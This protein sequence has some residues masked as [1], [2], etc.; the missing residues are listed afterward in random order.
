RPGLTA[1]KFVPEP[2]AGAGARMYRTGDRARWQADGNLLVLGR[3]DNQVKVRG[4][5]VELGEIEAVLRR[6]AS[7]TECVVIVREDRPG[8]RR[9]VAYVMGDADA[10]ALR[11]HLRGTLPEYMVP[12]AFVVLDAFPHTPTGKLDRKTLP[13]PEYA[14]AGAEA[15]PPRNAVEVQLIGLWEGLLGIEGVGPAQSFFDLGGNSLLALQ[16]FAKIHRVLGCDLPVAALYEGPTVRQMADAILERRASSA[17]PEA[18]SA[19]VALRVEGSL[20]PLFC[21]HPADRRV[22]VYAPLARHLGADQPVFGLQDLGA[23]LSRPI[24][25]IAAEYVTAL[26][27]VQPQGPYYLA[28]WSFGGFVAYEMASKLEREGERVAFVGM[29]DTFE[30]ALAQGRLEG[31]TGLNVEL[32][33]GIASDVAAQ[34]GRPFTIAREEMEGLDEDGRLRRAVEILHAHAAAPRG[35]D[36]AMLREHCT[37]IQAREASLAAYVPGPF[38]GPLTLFRAGTLDEEDEAYL[39]VLSAEERRTLGWCRRSPHPVEVR[40]APGEHVTMGIEPNVRA[41]AELVRESLASARARA[42]SRADSSG[43]SGSADL[44][45]SAGSADPADPALDLAR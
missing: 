23:D 43:S 27:T 10:A 41:L 11:G 2:F 14:H 8:D 4:F 21:V 29:L 26:R 33:L 20:P 38:S 42:A 24:P 32:V 36:A 35:F 34:M 9:L 31:D 44:P 18:A 16:L 28:G 3:T 6:H 15:G 7:V 39:A 19:V 25:A 45:D 5:R 1:E 22:L 40:V 30:P 17:A 37:V 13:A 12:D